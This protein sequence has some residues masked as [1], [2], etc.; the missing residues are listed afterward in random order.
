[1]AELVVSTLLV[2]VVMCAALSS[3]GQALF[4]QRKMADRVTG[5][6]LAQALL[7][8]ILTTA[9]EEPGGGLSLLGIDL[10]ETLGLKS[11]YDDVDDFDGYSESPPTNA[12]GSTMTGYSGWSRSVAVTG[13]NATTLAPTSSNNT[14]IKRVAVTAAYNGVTVYTA[15]G[16]RTAA[17]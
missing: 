16:Y 2:G 9:Y 14:G 5:R 6:Y 12:D 8:E 15:Y 17:P 13:V 1:L 11:T 7:A 3:T 4:T 10:L